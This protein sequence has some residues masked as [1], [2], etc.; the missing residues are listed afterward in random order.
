MMRDTFTVKEHGFLTHFLICGPAETDFSDPA[1][2]ANQL[3]YEAYLRSVLPRS[4]K[5]W[6]P[7]AEPGLPGPEGMPWRYYYSPGNWFVDLGSFY[8][9]L[10]RVELSAATILWVPEDLT[11]EAVLWSYAAVDVWCNGRWLAG[12]EKPVYKP[13]EKQKFTLP[14]AKGENYLYIKLQNL[15]VRDTRTIFGIQL[16]GRTDQIREV[17]PGG[18]AAAEMAGREKWLSGITRTG[19][20]LCFPAPAPADTIIVY[21]TEAAQFGAAGSKPLVRAIAG[22]AEAPLE[23]DYPF[24]TISCGPQEAMI[25][26]FEDI[27][28]QKP[29]YRNVQDEIVNRELTYARIGAGRGAIRNGGLFGMANLLARKAVGREWPTD[30]QNL[31]DC[32]EPVRKRFD[33]SDFTLSA[34]FRYLENYPVDEE[35]EQEIYEAV[36][37]YRYWMDQEGTDGMCFWSENHALLFYSNAMLAGKR[38]PKARFVRAGQTG[39]Q[40]YRTAK[41]RLGQWLDCVERDGFEE[42][43][44]SGYMAV[45]FAGLLNVIDYGDAN[46][47]GQA[48]SVADRLLKMLAVQTFK[49]TVLAPMGR[50]YRGVIYPCRQPVQMLINL[51]D[52]A[53]P[54]VDGEGEG[55][56]AFYATSGYRPPGELTALMKEP[57]EYR[58]QTGNAEIILCKNESWCMTSVQSGA[59]HG[60]RRWTNTTLTS[61]ADQNNHEYTRSLNERF[62]GTTCFVP[63]I[64]GYQ[65]HLWYGALDAETF[66]FTNHPG[67]TC[68]AGSMRPGYWYGNGVMPA[69]KQE[70]G[71]LG[72]IY[73]IPDAHPIHFTHLFW[74]DEKF[75][76]LQQ[77]ENWLF[78]RKGSG[79]LA[80]WTSGPLVPHD[81]WLFQCEYRVYGDE[82]AWLAIGGS[83]GEHGDFESFQHVC[84]QLQPE[85]DSAA[86]ELRT[87]SGFTLSY[88]AGSDE[89]QYVL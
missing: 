3:R 48:W 33:C 61:E 49:G 63:G 20:H 42:F 5:L 30:R 70:R 47:A 80:V 82:T 45:T 7:E 22:T 55:W 62:H 74:P 14:L 64:Y 28:R 35:L 59:E 88:R 6:E 71:Y 84:R 67:S 58:Y 31:R 53:T 24:I 76:Q 60:Q 77:T 15:G 41:D 68:E 65:Q 51:F 13:M 10:T 26:Q 54:W 75:E 89:T 78:G 56:A 2:D 72:L 52:P 4:Q 40:L 39:L 83:A 46:L 85:Y 34:L 32:L 27:R 8:S 29:L 43:L 12:I 44:S 73:V 25:R 11:A 36:T 18:E 81:D 66:I 37:G 57:A 17:I 38:Y 9:T 23:P 86:R 69:L 87:N 79:Y 19:E 16:S 50:V 21:Q 1:A